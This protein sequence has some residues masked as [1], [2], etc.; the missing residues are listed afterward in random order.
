MLKKA[1]GV[2]KKLMLVSNKT[3]DDVSVMGCT[4]ERDAL[5]STDYTTLIPKLQRAD[6]GGVG[7]SF[8]DRRIVGEIKVATLYD[9]I[10]KVDFAT[11]DAAVVRA[12][13]AAAL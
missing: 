2:M 3:A 8:W 7:A 5:F 12:A 6:E 11:V 1:N 13:A 10:L 9:K 4:A